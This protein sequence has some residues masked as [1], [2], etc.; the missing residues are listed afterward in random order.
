M[1]RNEEPVA[2]NTSDRRTMGTPKPGTPPA[3]GGG[4]GSA[5]F[6][7]VAYDQEALADQMREE[8][9]PKPFVETNRILQSWRSA[10]VLL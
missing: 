7:P 1:E 8:G 9:L 4:R 5:E 6:V 3:R 10:S 2:T